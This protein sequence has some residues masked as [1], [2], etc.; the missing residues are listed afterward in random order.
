[1]PCTPSIAAI[2]PA[3]PDNRS[4]LAADSGSGSPFHV[5]RTSTGDSRDGSNWRTSMSYPRRDSAAD[6]SDVAP[7]MSTARWTAGAASTTTSV[8]VATSTGQGWRITALDQRRQN[9]P[10]RSGRQ[11]TR[12]AFTRD[13]SMPRSA[14]S[15]VRAESTEK[16]TTSEPPKPIE[17]IDI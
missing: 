17:R 6:G 13:P 11:N 3:S 2:S 7:G 4:R 8:M 12:S 1:M 9:L 15:R 10:S 5:T 16:S 14:G